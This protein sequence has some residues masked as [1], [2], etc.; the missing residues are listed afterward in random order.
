MSHH[1]AQKAKS[2][3]VIVSELGATLFVAGLRIFVPE[4]AFVQDIEHAAEALLKL[5]ACGGYESRVSEVRVHT[6]EFAN[7]EQA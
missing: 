7:R 1:E 5:A 6:S 2:E 3:P 4:R